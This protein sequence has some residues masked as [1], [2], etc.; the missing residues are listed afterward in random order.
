M[1]AEDIVSYFRRIL[2]PEGIELTV[3]GERILPPRLL[4][5][6]PLKFQTRSARFFIGLL[7]RSGT[8]RP[9]VFT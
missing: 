9:S 1:D 8:S 3:N 6:L 4:L 5:R 2:V 7:L